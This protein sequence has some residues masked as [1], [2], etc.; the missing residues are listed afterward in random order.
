M[1][2]I[3]TAA[4]T[5][6]RIDALMATL[7]NPRHRQMLSS[8]R[9]HWRG[10]VSS[11][12]DAAFAVV[13]DDVRFALLGA[14][15]SGQAFEV[16]NI[17]DHRAVYEAMPNLGLNAGGAFSNER[18]AFAGWGL[19]MEATYS[20]VVYGA[21]LANVGEYDAEALYL[22]HAPLAMVCSFTEDGK[23]ATKRDYF[24]A[25]TSVEPADM[26]LLHRLTAL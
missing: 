14:L 16:T 26:D 21:M 2:I 12:L 13:C 18:F 4:E 6:G 25:V 3:S 8:F 7:E 19:M 24:G 5:F 10:E 22:F 17:R 9:A 15:P 23:L 11:D 20:N 1:G